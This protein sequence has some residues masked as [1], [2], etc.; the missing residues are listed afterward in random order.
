MGSGSGGAPHARTSSGSHL[1]GASDTS[2]NLFASDPGVWAY[3]QS[4]EDRVKQ[5]VDSVSAI[6]KADSAKQAQIGLLTT[7]VTAL[8]KQLQ[9]QDG[10]ASARQAQVGLLT[11]EV[12]ELRRQL[13]SPGRE[14][15]VSAP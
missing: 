8:K 12:T 9:A 3:I 15:D 13:P 14:A 1:G 6:Q 7:D 4:L 11:A 2:G 10:E 5:L